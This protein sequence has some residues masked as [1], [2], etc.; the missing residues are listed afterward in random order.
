VKREPVFQTEAELCAAFIEW[1]ARAGYR[2]YPETAEFDILAVD[3][4]GWQ[5]GIEAKLR[6]N[7]KV[8]SQ[9]LP[10]YGA[11]VGPDH[12]AILVP[13]IDSELREICGYLGLEIFYCMTRGGARRGLRHDFARD[14]QWRRDAMFDWNPKSRCDLPDYMPDVPAGVPAPIRLTPW[15]VAALKVLA[16]LEISGWLTRKEI[17]IFGIDA[18][19]WTAGD[20]W[21]VPFDGDPKRGGRF[22]RGEKCPRFDLQHPDVYAQIKAELI[23]TGEPTAQGLLEVGT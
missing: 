22:Q 9:A 18:R 20:G 7:V 8:I 11:E 15:K 12:R 14:T 16:R 1:A 21:L 4:D 19:R 13:G 10:R 23:E 3:S 6:M 17:S 2:C 5:I